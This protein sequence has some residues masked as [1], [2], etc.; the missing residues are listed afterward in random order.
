MVQDLALFP[1]LSVAENIGF[2]LNDWPREA[3]RGRVA[4]L[5]ELLA[6]GGLEGRLP[7]SISGGQ[8]QRV[9]LGRALAP[10][11]SLLL[12]DEPFSSLD[13]PVRNN[14]RREVAALRR[15]LGLVALFVTH[16]IQEAYALGDRIAVYD[17]GP[18]CSWARAATSF[19]SRPRCG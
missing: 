15:R 14:L 3:R 11:P 9:A 18:C 2:G 10:Q 12:L 17:G 19:A 13:A 8:Q 7:R 4:E 1:H 16:D 6:L 5:V